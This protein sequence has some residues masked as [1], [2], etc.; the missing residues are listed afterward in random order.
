MSACPK[1]KAVLE[2]VSRL[3][4]K[5]QSGL[6]AVRAIRRERVEVKEAKP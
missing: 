2:S 4:T 3:A 5:V 1:E 6:E